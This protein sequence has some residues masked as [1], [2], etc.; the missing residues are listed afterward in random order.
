MKPVAKF[1]VVFGAVAAAA[2]VAVAMDDPVKAR[3]ELMKSVGKSAKTSAQMVKGQVPFDA[4]AAE[5]AMMTI[6]GVPE[7][8][9]K[10]FPKGTSMKENP[11]T[12][13]SPKIWEDMKGFTEAANKMKAASDAGAAAAKKGP[14]E[15]KAAFG[16]L[17]KTCKS[18]HEGYRIKK[19]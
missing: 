9:L 3:K 4:A 5:A 1:A 19:Q 8:Y 12:E 17:I 16:N 6:S 14:N 15:F 18:C 11:D 2:T 10:L 13:A 7:K